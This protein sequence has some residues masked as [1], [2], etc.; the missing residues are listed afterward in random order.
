[1]DATKASLLT[2]ASIKS[3]L[4]GL[5][6][7]L[8][9][10]ISNET[11]GRAI[12]DSQMSQVLSDIGQLKDSGT[13]LSMRV[14]GQLAQMQEDVKCMDARNVVA[15]Q[16]H[17]KLLHTMQSTMKDL[18]ADVKNH[19][20]YLQDVDA[21]EKTQR[22]QMTDLKGQI[23]AVNNK[24]N[25]QRDS[26][27]DVS[28]AQ[29]KI[30][31]GIQENLFQWSSVSDK[32]QVAENLWE[33]M[34]AQILDDTKKM[35]LEER[36]E[37]ASLDNFIESLMQSMGDKLLAGVNVGHTMLRSSQEQ[38]LKHQDGLIASMMS[39]VKKVL[40]LIRTT[41]ENKHQKQDAIINKLQAEVRR[42]KLGSGGQRSAPAIR[43][44]K[45]KTDLTEPSLQSQP[46][47]PMA[48]D[49]PV[50]WQ[51][52]QP[53]RPET[54]A[55]KAAKL[56][57]HNALALLTK[58][59]KTRKQVQMQPDTPEELEPAPKQAPRK[60][61]HA[62]SYQAIDL[63]PD[64]TQEAPKQAPPPADGKQ[65][66]GS[67]DPQPDIIP[68]IGA[69]SS[70]KRPSDASASS[71]RPKKQRP[72]FILGCS[73]GDAGYLLSENT[74]AH[75]RTGHWMMHSDETQARHRVRMLR[76]CKSNQIHHLPIVLPFW[77]NLTEFT[78]A[79]TLTHHEGQRFIRSREKHEAN[80]FRLETVLARAKW[81]RALG[82]DG[83]EPVSLGAHG[84]ASMG[85]AAGPSASSSDSDSS[86]LSSSD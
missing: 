65:R 58:S 34:K 46:S 27:L 24:L 37:R 16:T 10:K 43:R 76:S 18:K 75:G 45:P 68:V 31:A 51:P 82:H 49:I 55:D 23:H 67:A 56:A 80:W 26:Q 1:M 40:T 86:G 21:N 13:M 6:K 78:T 83:Y 84:A 25:T 85:H 81:I 47:R 74:N 30:L 2:L 15:L 64:S 63:I 60:R 66:R 52:S 35:I 4:E 33:N 77:E 11:S 7:S 79:F 22:A 3:R 19:A 71:P 48:E 41:V 50:A 53:S 69:S 28:M 42:A 8:I 62:M 20:H 61:R 38:K 12:L 72:I 17:A 57:H 59:K 73:L 9:A 14:A 70:K 39:D 29:G 36:S 44:V 32:N 54:L 5:E